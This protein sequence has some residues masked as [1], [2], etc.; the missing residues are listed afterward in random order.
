[1]HDHAPAL[2]NRREMRQDRFALRKRQVSAL[3]FSA[4][5]S[6]LVAEI[7]AGKR[8][9]EVD[10]FGGSIRVL[11]GVCVDR[12]LMDEFGARMSERV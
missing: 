2:L 12:V 11:S 3:D 1:M 7:K 9:V 4:P 8:K 6:A 10:G 5:I